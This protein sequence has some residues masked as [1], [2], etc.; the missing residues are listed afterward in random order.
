MKRLLYALLV[1]IAVI[2]SGEAGWRVVVDPLGPQD[3]SGQWTVGY[4]SEFPPVAVP[5]NSLFNRL[6]QGRV[7]RYNSLLQQWTDTDTAVLNVRSFKA[8]C[9]DITDDTAAIQNAID[10]VGSVATAQRTGYQPVVLIP[11]PCLITNTLTVRRKSVVIQGAGWGRRDGSANRAYLRWGGPAGVP[12]LKIQDALNVKIKNLR[13]IGSVTNPPSAG[14]NFNETDDSWPLSANTVEDVFMGVLDNGEAD[15]GDQFADGILLDG[16]GQN[17]AELALT[18]VRINHVSRDGIHVGSVQSVNISLQSVYLLH[19]GRAGIYNSGYIVG[20][21][22]ATAN[23]AVDIKHPFEDDLSNI[24]G[25]RTQI[26]GFFSELAGRLAEIDAGLLLLNGSSFALT[27]SLNADGKVIVNDSNA[28]QTTVEIRNLRWF[29][30]GSPPTPP[31]LAMAP[32]STGV[33]HIVL[34]NCD[35]WSGLTGGTNGMDVA[36]TGANARAYVF[37]RA[38]PAGTT[39]VKVAQNFLAGSGLQWDINRFD[40]PSTASLKLGASVAG[41][42]TIRIPHGSAPSSPVDGDI[43]T[44]TAGLFVHVNGVTVG[45]LS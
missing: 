36:T 13:I 21:N 14:I 16:L 34:D 5:P 42:A 39:P 26:D 9:D 41:G 25:A 35:G 3:L 31:Y 38:A 29:T 27:P 24:T 11:G 19:C 28:T 20:Q 10:S 12:M 23:N 6:D 17:N 44:T 32:Q 15:N 33:R 8:A 43:W 18:N 1:S 30:S 45:P 2:Q 7:Y 40:I 37:Y 22:V 4:G